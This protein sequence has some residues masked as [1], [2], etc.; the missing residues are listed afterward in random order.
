MLVASKLFKTPGNFADPEDKREPGGG[1]REDGVPGLD[2]SPLP[3]DPQ[4]RA[5]QAARC[6]SC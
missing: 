6:Q 1:M 4:P 3:P 5:G 2:P